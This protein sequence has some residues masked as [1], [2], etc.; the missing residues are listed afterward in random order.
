[1]V[2]ISGVQPEVRYCPTCKEL[3]Q[4]VPR[5][6]VATNVRT[7]RWQKTPTSTV[8]RRGSAETSSRSTKTFL[9]VGAVRGD[10]MPRAA[11]LTQGSEGLLTAAEKRAGSGG[12]S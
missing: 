9:D 6:P 12:K 4:N 5:S 1:M 7:E 11:N 8:A 3:F 10:A 2:F